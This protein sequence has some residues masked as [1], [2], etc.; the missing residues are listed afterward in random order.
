MKPCGKLW[1][2]KV[3]NRK[4]DG[5]LYPAMLTI[6]PIYDRPGDTAGDATSYSHFVA[7]QTDLSEFEACEH[8]L[9][10]ARRMESI[11]TLV[12]GIA[13]E[14][15]NMLAGITGNV[16]MLRLRTRNIPDVTHQLDQI[17]SISFRA[18]DMIE[19]LLTFARKDVVRMQPL[20]FNAFITETL[21]SLR[22]SLHENICEKASTIN[23]VESNNNML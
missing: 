13:H 6:S 10:Q 12:G 7:I 21:K 16:F 19:Q 23:R 15:N 4:K 3:I 17:E 5:S 14:F 2:G 1:H 11:G 18:A 22:L 9:Q 8:K 20:A